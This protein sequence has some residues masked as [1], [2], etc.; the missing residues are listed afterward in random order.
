MKQFTL[1]C[2]WCQAAFTSSYDTTLYC[3]RSHKEQASAMRRRQRNPEY[4]PRIE[5]TKYC[6]GCGNQFTTFKSNKK[7]CTSDCRKWF[8]SQR[9]RDRDNKYD[10][11]R[12]P[13]FRRRIYFQSEGKCAICF[14]QID[15]TIKHPHKQSFS[16]DH[17]IPRSKGGSHTAENLQAA[18]LGCNMLK[19]DSTNINSDTYII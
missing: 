3:C 18:H 6:S 9:L 4:R 15:L 17:I 12:T 10:N 19:S 8:E 7:F 5:H 13:S 2:L 14:Q 1:I 16:I 11:A